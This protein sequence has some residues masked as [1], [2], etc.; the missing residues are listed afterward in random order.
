[1]IT[2][3][4]LVAGISSCESTGGSFVD[5]PPSPVDA[6]PAAKTP[7]LAWHFDSCISDGIPSTDVYLEVNGTLHPVADNGTAEYDELKR[8]RWGRSG[9][10]ADALTACSSWF[11]GSGDVIYVTRE[12]RK[13]AVYR[14]LLDEARD[15][16]PFKRI[17]TIGW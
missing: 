4:I 15:A 12:G 1:M 13:L 2:L 6:S 16:S 9:V 14:S 10:P 11:A 3:L 5:P 17:K 7:E 8:S